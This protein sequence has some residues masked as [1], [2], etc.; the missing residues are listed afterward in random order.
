MNTVSD[1]TTAIRKLPSQP[2]HDEVKSLIAA[3]ECLL[4]EHTE[5]DY[6][7][8]QAHLQDAHGACDDVY[9]TV[10]QPERRFTQADA[11]AI[12]K[13]AGMPDLSIRRAA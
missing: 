6:S 12:C 10:R 3:V 8:V 4:E 9:A 7:E 5:A 11:D 2:T 1:I 13:R